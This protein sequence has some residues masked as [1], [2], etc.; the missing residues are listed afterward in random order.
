M[1]AIVVI[2]LSDASQA[3]S[4][5]GG[6]G[7]K[8]EP[9]SCRPDCVEASWACGGVGGL[10][11]E[12]NTEGRQAERNLCQVCLDEAPGHHDHDVIDLLLDVGWR[13]RLAEGLVNDAVSDHSRKNG[14]NSDDEDK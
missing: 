10:A 14:H 4:S 2:V 8:L 7:G 12:E 1:S 6:I 5:L 3:A 9:L 13:R 11:A